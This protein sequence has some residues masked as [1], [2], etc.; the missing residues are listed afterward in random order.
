MD[1]AST[2][3]SRPRPI[4]QTYD[5][6]I[7]LQ[8]ERQ[9]PRPYAPHALHLPDNPWTCYRIHVALVALRHLDLLHYTECILSTNRPWQF[10]LKAKTQAHSLLNFTTLLHLHDPL[11][12]LEWQTYPLTLTR[13]TFAHSH[14]LSLEARAHIYNC[15]TPPLLHALYREHN[16]LPDFPQAP[17]RHW[18]RSQAP[19]PQF[20]H[21]RPNWLDPDDEYA[22]KL[23][24]LEPPNMTPSST[25][26]LRPQ[27]RRQGNPSH[28]QHPLP[29]SHPGRSRTPG[30]RTH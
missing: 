2:T 10:F 26:V 11:P 27:P 18:L 23:L 30:P 9:R 16:L 20:H 12:T 25:D 7:T 24:P 3:F 4:P 17:G 8:L 28:H 1:R 13:I 14:P 29:H 21:S 19:P 5:L 6:L 22:T 15:S